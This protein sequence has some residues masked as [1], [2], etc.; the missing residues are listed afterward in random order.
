MGMREAN[1]PEDFI[2]ALE[3]LYVACGVSNLRMQDWGVTR[4]EL[5]GHAGEVKEKFGDLFLNDPE[6]LSVEDCYKIFIDSY[7]A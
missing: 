4:E 2:C 1:N 6:E 5:K 3:K 7:D